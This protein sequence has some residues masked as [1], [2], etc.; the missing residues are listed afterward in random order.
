MLDGHYGLLQLHERVMVVHHWPRC[1]AR[2]R[3]GSSGMGL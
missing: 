3:L 2:C 1:R